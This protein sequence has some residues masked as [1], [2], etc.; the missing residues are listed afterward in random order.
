MCYPIK[1]LPFWYL[2]TSFP[3]HLAT[4]KPPP[5][6]RLRLYCRK[7]SSNIQNKMRNSREKKCSLNRSIIVFERITGGRETF[8]LCDCVEGIVELTFTES[9]CIISIWSKVQCQ[10]CQLGSTDMYL[11][12]IGLTEN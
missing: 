3:D 7:M 4:N 12:R 10:D 11:A 2:V 8:C 1:N 5:R 6:I 9:T